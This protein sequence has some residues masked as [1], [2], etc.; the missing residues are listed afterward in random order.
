M[1]DSIENTPAKEPAL[2]FPGLAP[3][4]DAV[5]ELSWPIIRLTVGASILV[6]GILKV[7]GPGVFNFANGLTNRGIPGGVF[8]SSLVF[9]NETIGAVL[10]MLGLFTRPIAASLALECAVITFVAHWA[11]GW[12]F[13]NAK[14]GW[15]Y[16]LV[17]GLVMFAISLR[18][19]G[20]YSLDRKIGREV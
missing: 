4:Y 15:E 13:S 14:G 9:F 17:L 16:P 11:N 8:S 12:Q 18:G 3:F 1:T 6:H 19:G 5:R 20:P 2:F 10:I 7:T